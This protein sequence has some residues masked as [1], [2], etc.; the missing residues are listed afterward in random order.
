MA[1]KVFISSTFKDIDLARDLSRRLQEVDISV[2]PLDQRVEPVG[3][4]LG[5]IVQHLSR[6]DE[7]FVILTDNSVENPYLMY[8]LGAAT[9]LRKRVTPIIVGLEPSKLPSLL[10]GMKYIKYPDLSKYISAL[11]KRSKAA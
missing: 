7:V 11:E 3:A 1:Y 8:E 6:A 4:N 9:S 2:Y 5:K 10:K